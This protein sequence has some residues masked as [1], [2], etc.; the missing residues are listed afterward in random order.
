MK[1]RPVVVVA[2]C[3]QIT[4]GGCTKNSEIV[5][6]SS[7]G[8]SVVVDLLKTATSV[9][10]ALAANASDHEIAAD[11][12][13]DSALEIP[14]TLNGTT[15]TESTDSASVSGSTLTISSGGTYRIKGTLTNGQIH[16]NASNNGTVRLILDGVTLTNSSTSPLYIE[17]AAKT[18]L[19]LADN[20]Q[21]FL[22]DA[23]SYVFP[24]ADEDEPN[25]AV[26]SKDNLTISGNGSLTVKGNYNDAIASKDGLVIKSGTI[27]VTAVDDGIRGK[28]YLAM[29]GGTITVIATGDGLKSDN[30]EDATKG[31]IYIEDGT[32]NITAGGDGF[33]AE[34][35]ALISNGTITIT[36]GGG[37]SSTVSGDASAKG[38]KG[39]ASVIVGNGNLAISSADDAIHSNNLVV[40]NGGAFTMAT[41]DDGIHADS[42][43]GINGGT[44]TITKCY[45]GIESMALVINDGTI[46]LNSSDDGINGAG[47]NDGS[48]AGGWGGTVP[49]AGNRYLAING[50][51]IAVTA[52]GDGI[53]VN[54]SIVMTGGTVIV[55]GPTSNGNG[56]L[57]YDATFNVSG[58]VIVAAGSSGMA[59]A[60]SKTSAQ[61]SVLMT[62][63]STKSAG[64]LFHIQASDGTDVL[65]FKSAKAFQSVA[66][67]SPNLVTGSTYDVYVGGSST[68]SVIDGVYV[69][70]TYSSGTKSA[71]LTVSGRVTSAKGS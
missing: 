3:I 39:V 16:V 46:H 5:S 17:K 37:S 67:C 65:T 55:H 26:F 8:S 25:A 58:G 51:Y 36:S 4:L 28:D 29:K 57:D 12:T 34:T 40:I 2:V 49:S 10:T 14:I 71:S 44:I 13:W 62:F 54:G 23:S 33:A 45:E 15:I 70:G 27:T 63:T 59:M 9:K 48:A 64:T 43:L 7:D 69:G 41:A 60:P 47:G 68:G 42:L 11:Y 21:N 50:G 31:Y 32:L 53:D 38:I 18:V 19:V 6:S 1:S 20:S 61:N 56:P 30:D 52:A 24:S 35:D 22:T 66:F